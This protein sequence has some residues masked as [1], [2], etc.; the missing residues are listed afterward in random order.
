MP[1]IISACR[2]LGAACG[3]F[4]ARPI[5]NPNSLGNTIP[6]EHRRTKRWRRQR[7]SHSTLWQKRTRISF[8]VDPAKHTATES[9]QVKLRNHR[10]EPVEI[11]V[12]EPAT[13]WHSWEVIS[14]S[15]F[16]TKKD[17][18]KLEFNVPVKA[19]EERTLTYTIRYVN[20]PAR[21][22]VQ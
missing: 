12:T 22:E 1:R 10:K 14:K 4:G 8:E 2:C 15:D 18:D 3:S 16:F 21:N 9:F 20:L 17:A 13:R 19:G 6:M 5:E 11:R 7:D